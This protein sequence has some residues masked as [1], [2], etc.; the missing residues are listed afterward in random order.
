MISYNFKR[1]Y[2]NEGR[3]TKLEKD[4]NIGYTGIR[5]H[6]SFFRNNEKLGPFWSLRKKVIVC[7]FLVGKTN[8]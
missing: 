2:E 4:W 5:S 3:A 8:N 1:V 6:F 7:L